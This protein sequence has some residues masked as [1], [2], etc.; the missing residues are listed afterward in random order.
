MNTCE[1]YVRLKPSL[2]NVPENKW[3]ISESYPTMTIEILVV[4]PKTTVKH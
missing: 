3:Q 4:H 2:E 1:F